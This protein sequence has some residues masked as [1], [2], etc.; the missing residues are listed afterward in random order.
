MSKMLLKDSSMA[1][2][3][4]FSSDYNRKIYGWE[5]ARKLKMNQKTVSN[6][7]NNLEK[8]HI[9]KFSHE[10][11]N[12]YYL[13]NR[14]NPE[15]KEVIKFIDIKRKIDFLEK[16]KKIREL[17]E[18]LEQKTKGILVIFGSYAKQINHENSDLDV[19]IIG[20]IDETEDL[21]KIYNI[22]INIIKSTR[23]KFNKNDIFI[24]EITK[25]HII[26]KGLEDFVELIW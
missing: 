12:K 18:K 21:E 5:V 4:E 24:K 15:I 1:I 3:A 19:F 13:L 2:L 26:L 23:K 8:E 10:G 22:K 17:F 11:R 20:Q 14:F 6:V 7:L 9:L 25:N 16:N